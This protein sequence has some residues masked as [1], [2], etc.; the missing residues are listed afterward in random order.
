MLF[1]CSFSIDHKNS[2]P[3]RQFDW[4]EGADSSQVDIVLAKA[5][6]QEVQSYY[7]VLILATDHG[8]R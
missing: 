6:D 7:E 5:L 2:D 3:E 1:F 4:V 8:K